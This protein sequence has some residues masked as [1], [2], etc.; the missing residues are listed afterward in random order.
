MQDGNA[1]PDSQ[2]LYARWLN[3]APGPRPP[4]HYTLLGLPLFT[5]DLQEIEAAAHRL[6]DLLDVHALHLDPEKR[7]ACQ[8][9]MNEVAQARSVLADA[10]RRVDYDC[11]LLIQHGVAGLSL[12]SPGASRQPASSAPLAPPP[13]GG[14][15]ALI[16]ARLSRPAYAVFLVAV[17]IAVGS[18]VVW[19]WVLHSGEQPME[20]AVALPAP[21]PAAPVAQ[22]PPS[23]APQPPEPMTPPTDLEALQEF[24]KKYPSAA[25][26]PAEIGKQPPAALVVSPPSAP[27]AQGK[28]LSLDLG[29]GVMMRLNYI[30]PGTF[31]MGSPDYDKNH[32][33]DETPQHPVTL[34]VG[35][36]MAVT[37]VTQEQY[38]AVMGQNPSR[39]KDPKNP[40]EM[41]SWADATEFCRKVSEKT[42]RKARLP[43]EAEW[44]FACR[45]GTASS[46]SFGDDNRALSDYAWYIDNSAGAT[47]PVGQKNPNAWGLYDMLGN[48]F[49]WCADWSGKYP[50]SPVGNPR[51]PD[52]GTHRVQR[53]GG[54]NNNAMIPRSAFRCC[55]LP[56][57]RDAYTGFRVV[58]ESAATALVQA[59]PTTAAPSTANLP[60]TTAAVVVSPPSAPVQPPPAPAAQGNTL[61]LDIGKGVT[62]KLVL[63]PAG[64]FMMGSPDSEQGRRGDE[65][66]QHE[67][68]I[69]KPFYLGLT[70][71]T[72]AQY[73]A[74]MGT[75]PSHFKGATNPV[76]MVSWNDATEFC[77]KLS[78]KTRQAVRLPTEAEWE[79]ACRAGTKTRF[80]F[81][82]SDSALGD[83]AWCSSNSGDKT[84]PV[85]QKK[86]NAWG[87]YDMHGNVREWCADRY[88]GYPKG[89]V[90]DPFG[91]AS[92]DRRM[93]R[94]GSWYSGATDHFR[95]AYRLNFFAPSLRNFS[96]GFRC[97]KTL[98]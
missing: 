52:S 67:V 38:Q 98:P 84:Q 78:E 3:I 17:L 55:A 27:A 89:T 85:G 57:N 91:T 10:Q 63:I 56:L 2:D 90:S 28:E 19:A 72:Q 20:T 45:A 36:Y 92:G 31:F 30:P 25:R 66:P 74:V 81:G 82:D 1:S 40:V 4:D 32:F 33:S 95:C 59:P 5:A 11:T 39:F 35:F 6:L 62:M 9:L 14:S 70:E 8:R 54:C 97:A 77:K 42:G 26:P 87:L 83:Y 43:T 94:G 24:L 93:L 15:F 76:E 16:R 46:F 50:N 13:E 34:T 51:G 58:V 23:V 61:S 75:N 41:V 21:A 7:A 47:H 18:L 53:G 29:G 79:Y 73:E 71:V 88:G 69:T 65:G 37:E 80:S 60:T 49:E 12:P 44:E 48:V 86:P 64:K 68:I 96:F 22:T